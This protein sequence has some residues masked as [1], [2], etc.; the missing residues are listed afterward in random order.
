MRRQSALAA[1]GVAAFT[2]LVRIPTLSEP[3]WYYAEGVFRSVA[4]ANS[5][6]VTLYVGVFDVQPPGI[7]WLVRLLLAAGA[8]HFVVQLAV[9]LF[10]VAAAVLTYAIARR[11][12]DVW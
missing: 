7:F 4:W 9:T 2:L 5:K 6:G 1:L 3:R 11:W 8:N 12:M 10:A